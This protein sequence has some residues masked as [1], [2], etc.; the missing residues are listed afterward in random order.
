[1][2]DTDSPVLANESILSISLQ[3]LTLH[4]VVFD[5]K[6]MALDRK[7]YQQSPRIE[8]GEEYFTIRI[9][10]R[11]NTNTQSSHEGQGRTA[12]TQDASPFSSALKGIGLRLPAL[13]SCC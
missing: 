1:M 4:R 3:R 13:L 11:Q 9:P 8:R 12:R 2:D 6:T 7:E 5:W 10:W